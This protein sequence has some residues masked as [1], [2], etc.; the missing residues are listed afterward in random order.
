[1]Y[2]HIC[3]QIKPIIEFESS[4][5]KHDLNFNNF[6]RSNDEKLFVAHRQHRQAGEAIVEGPQECWLEREGCLQMATPPSSKDWSYQIK[7]QRFGHVMYY[8]IVSLDLFQDI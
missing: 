4:S 8:V 1:M 6:F 3:N 7:V 2:N 5:V